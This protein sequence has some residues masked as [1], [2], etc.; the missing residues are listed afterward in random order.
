MRKASP[1]L[2]K[3]IPYDVP[4]TDDFHPVAGKSRGGR[5]RRRMFSSGFR[6]LKQN[7]RAEAA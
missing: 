1:E 5:L 2:K 6:F 7:R 3:R 4:L